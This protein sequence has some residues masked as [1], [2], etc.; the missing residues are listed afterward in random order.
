MECAERRIGLQELVKIRQLK[1]QRT[2]HRR[3]KKG[4]K[5]ELF[6]E[7]WNKNDFPTNHNGNTRVQGTLREQ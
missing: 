4:K 5:S 7:D 1:E 2:A 3:A 6:R